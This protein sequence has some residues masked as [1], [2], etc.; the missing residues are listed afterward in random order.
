MKNR[1][2]TKIAFLLL[3]FLVFCA[4]APLVLFMAPAQ[5]EDASACYSIN[6]GDTRTYCLARAHH[7]ASQC[8]AIQRPDLRAQCRAEVRK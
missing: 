8:Y 6:D 1:H 5:A 3:G 2:L 7:D 4:A